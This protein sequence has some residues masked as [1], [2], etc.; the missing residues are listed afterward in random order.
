[1]SALLSSSGEKAKAFLKEES[2]SR[3][4]SKKAFLQDERTA[5]VTDEEA[6]K[7]VGRSFEYIVALMELNLI[8][9][10]FQMNHYLYEGFK[11]ELSK[12][13]ERNVVNGADWD[14]LIVPDKT[15]T[16]RLEELKEQIAGLSDSLQDVQRIWI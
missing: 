2:E 11:T 10:K 5:M 9:L 13:F 16:S 1:M 4:T 6:E 15:V 8:I 3:T 7:I 12:R 14:T